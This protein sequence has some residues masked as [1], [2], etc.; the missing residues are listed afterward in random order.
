MFA[1]Q[2]GVI[3][4]FIEFMPLEEDRVWAPSTVVPL[5][6]I[7]QCMAEYRPLVEIPHAKSESARR[8][9]FDD[10]IG[11][12]GLIAPG[13]HRFCVH[14]SRHRITAYATHSTCLF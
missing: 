11:E 1:R 5:D 13:S 8:Y 14:C 9:R 3:V 4:R 10:G 12:I 2:E 7:L 6:E